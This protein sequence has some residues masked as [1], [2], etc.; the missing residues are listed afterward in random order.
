MQRN[1]SGYWVRQIH[2]CKQKTE[3]TG[4]LGFYVGDLSFLGTV[5]HK[6]LCIVY[7]RYHK[8]IYNF[9]FAK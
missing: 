9:T 4:R 5:K 2:I 3:G 8:K 6:L 1:V 7:L